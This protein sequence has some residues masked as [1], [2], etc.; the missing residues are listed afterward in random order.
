MKIDTNELGCFLNWQ[1]GIGYLLQFSEHQK[2]LF[3]RQT[4]MYKLELIRDH[5]LQF[6]QVNGWLL[7]PADGVPTDMGTVKPIVAQYWIPKDRF[8]LAFIF[9]DSIYSTGGCWVKRPG[10]NWEW[11]EMS[12]SE[13]DALLM[14][15]CICDPSPCGWWKPRVVWAGVRIG[16]W[17]G[18]RG[19]EDAGSNPNGWWERPDVDP[20]GGYGG[21]D[22]Y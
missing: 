18:W 14:L 6:R 5:P 4:P 2:G 22:H 9:H 20:A 16:G 19:D 10:H 17:V 8:T 11:L 13:A 12:R 1:Q 21:G 7:M 3:G 15:M